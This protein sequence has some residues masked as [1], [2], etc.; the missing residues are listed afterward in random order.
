MSFIPKNMQDD[1]DNRIK[2]TSNKK[3]NVF[4]IEKNKDD[5]DNISN[6]EIAEIDADVNQL[7]IN[8]NDSINKPA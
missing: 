1:L 6:D 3:K 7:R 5:Y 8:I 2:K 4:G